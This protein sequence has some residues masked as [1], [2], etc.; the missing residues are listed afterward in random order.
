M[1]QAEDHAGVLL[2]CKWQ[3]L[4]AAGCFLWPKFPSR[5]M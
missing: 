1:L 5:A 3:V 4:L 2:Q